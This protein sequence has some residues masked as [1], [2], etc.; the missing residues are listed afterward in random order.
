[1]FQSVI[2]AWSS[3]S[4]H[5]LGSH[6]RFEASHWKGIHL[7]PLSKPHS[8]K[9]ILHSL[10]RFFL[11]SRF[12]FVCV[13]L[14]G[15]LYSQKLG[16]CVIIHVSDQK[17]VLVGNGLTQLPG[18]PLHLSAGMLTP[19]PVSLQLCLGSTRVLPISRLSTS[20][21]PEAGS[22]HVS[23]RAAEQGT[24]WI[25]LCGFDSRFLPSPY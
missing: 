14:T 10:D 3:S 22:P 6:P 17:S 1:M 11:L 19:N 7:L 8:R 13:A 4:S 9:A 21:Q 18:V 25:Y 16:L 5:C 2:D 23:C 15:T 24:H 20:M 12:R